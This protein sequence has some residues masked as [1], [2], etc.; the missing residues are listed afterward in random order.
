MLSFRV[1][2]FLCLFGIL[3]AEK[4]AADAEGTTVDAQTEEEEGYFSTLDYILLTA[5][6]AA[7]GY[8]FLFKGSDD[9]MPEYEIKTLSVRQESVVDKGFIAK[10][11]KTN[12]RLV[13]FYGSQTGTAEEFA[14]RL[15]K[16]GARYGLKGLVADPEE[17]DMDNISKLKDL[18]E[19]VGGPC[20]AVFMM[21][22]YGEGDPTDNAMDFNEKLQNDSIEMDGLR[23]AVFGLG[24]KTYEHFN[25]MG[26]FVDAK[27]EAL[28]GRRVHDLG[29]GDDDA[30]LEDDFITWKEAF[31]TKVCSELGIEANSDD[32]NTRQYLHKVLEEGDFKPEKVYTGEVARLRSYITQRPPFD[33]KNPY[34]SPIKVNK[35]IH[36][37]G[38]GRHCMH[39][40]V[41]IEGSRIRYDAGDHVAVYPTN[42]TDLV[43][44]LGELLKIDMDTVFTMTNL[45]EDSSKKHPF[46]C[47]TTYRT[48]L[49]HYVDISAI[50]RTHILLELAK[51]TEDNEQKSKLE[52]MSGTTPEGKALYQKWIVDDVRHLTHILEDLNSCAPPVDHL[53]ELLPRL[54][55]RF[56]SIASSAKIHPT[57]VHICGVVVEYATPTGRTNKGVATTWLR[58]KI[59]VGEDYPKV[60]I[61]VR[62]SQFRLPNRVQTPVIMIGPGSGLAPFRGFIQERAWQ[63][64]QNKP[65][66]P[67]LLY[68]GCRNKGHDYIYQDELEAWAENGVLDL[69]VA[70]S[71]DQAEK[72]YVT[73]LLRE[74]G[75]KV[76][77]LLDQGG[78]LYVCGDAKMMAKD[79]RNIVKEI[80]QEH[81]G[82]SSSEAET[83][84][85]K[86]ETQ[87]RYSADVWS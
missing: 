73:H 10:M 6:A 56:Y 57:S 24:N 44:R 27:L 23:Y 33:V 64:E 17:E 5:V 34:M 71:R 61:Y 83:F 26:I 78:H 53:L 4:T 37:E 66:G 50:P 21:A 75:E 49:L 43:D 59:A 18:E 9:Q 84:V 60:P 2:F 7:A 13:V 30:N 62:R 54:Q 39:I 25:A 42:N 32:I 69:H 81:G 31:W 77:K 52:L 46:P 1:Q 16:E 79:V 67:T 76:W 45:D 29:S 58:E 20:L 28:G 86:L 85:K 48:A 80:S 87:K 36:K 12:R 65:V 35:N 74:T 40:E 8:Y 47:P 19:E 72:K 3:V 15:A 11:R 82:M 41:D 55:P 38:S 51:Y 68:F 63:K 70:F 22:T 14:G